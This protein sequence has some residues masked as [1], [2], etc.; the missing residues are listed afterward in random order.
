MRTCT[1]TQI[2]LEN[3]SIN[4][5]DFTWR[6]LGEQSTAYSPSIVLPNGLVDTVI[7]LELTANGSRCNTTVVKDIKLSP[8][9]LASQLPNVLTP[10]GDGINDRWCFDNFKG[11]QACF[12]ISIY[13]RWGRPVFASQNPNACWQPTNEQGV[14]YYL[15]K[16]GTEDYRGFI[17]VL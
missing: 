8:N 3:K 4:A 11:Y 15:L 14:F 5:N 2:T 12:T 9:N 6:W 16:L 13:D 17:T 7:R 10:N 1:E